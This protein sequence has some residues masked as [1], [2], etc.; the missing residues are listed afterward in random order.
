MIRFRH[1]RLTALGVIAAAALTV[2]SLASG[3]AASLSVDSAALTAYRSC[4]ITATPSTTPAVADSEAA[5]DSAN[6]NFGLGAS[7]N[8]RS[9]NSARNRRIYVRFDL[10]ACTA[11][12]PA[13]AVVKTAELRVFATTLPTACRTLDVFRV[14]AAWPETGITWTSQPFGTGLNN[15]P[16]AQRTS[17]ATVGSAPCQ[18]STI[19]RYVP[20]TVTAD[21]QAWVSGTAV[22]NGWMIRDDA[23]N[24]SQN[25]TVTFT[26]KNAGQ[27]DRAPQLTIT[28]GLS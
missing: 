8:V 20:W 19:F 22:N 17:Y 25:R 7:L 16:S 26:A 12:I 14:T 9:Y 15:P 5:Q 1:G 3:F 18:N 27:L 28:W 10:T 24:S 21:V 23:E 2:S 11:Q 6:T 4:L 13:T